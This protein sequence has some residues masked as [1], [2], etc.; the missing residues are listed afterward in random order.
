MN[1]CY[2]ARI[3]SFEAETQTATV[4]LMIERYFSDLNE[5]YQAIPTKELV[6]VPCHFPKGGGHSITMPVTVGDDCLVFFAQRGIDHWL[7]DGKEETGGLLGRPSPQHKR[8]HSKTDAIALIGFGSGITSDKP[9]VIEDFND[10]AIEIRNVDRTQRI[11]LDVETK[12]IEV[13][14]SSNI[15]AIADK[16]I[17]ASC[18]NITV[19]AKGNATIKAPNILLDGDVKFTGKMVDKNGIDHVTHKHGIGDYLDM[20][21]RPLK[22]GSSGVPE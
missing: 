4:K 20:E 10:S 6:D 14:T 8:R 17:E 1:T 16:N 11:S 18:N 21:S 3:V 12:D 5:K 7:Y 22:A 15:K 19:T 2:P 13:I 9:K